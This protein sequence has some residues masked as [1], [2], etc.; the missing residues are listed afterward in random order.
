MFQ[1]PTYR[2]SQLHGHDGEAKTAANPL[3]ASRP[4]MSWRMGLIV[5]FAVC[6]TSLVGSAGFFI[7]R[8]PNPMTQSLI[9]VG[10]MPRTFTYNRTFAE[11]PSNKTNEAWA[12]LFPPGG[13][14]F[15]TPEMA[16]QR[17]TLSVFHQLHCLDGIRH[18]YWVIYQAMREGRNLKDSELLGMSSPGHIRHCIDLLRQSLM[19][20]ADTT[21]EFK[22]ESVNGV[23]GFGVQHQCHN[24]DQLLQLIAEKQSR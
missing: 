2:Y 16:S 15:S 3:L 10:V 18:G 22:N 5:L 13:G 8:A 21:L 1:Q 17:S 11:V 20:S 14:F 12:S 19:C 7:G 9:P 23:R 6:W 24:W 4:Y